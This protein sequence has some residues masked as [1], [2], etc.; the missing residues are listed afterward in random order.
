VPVHSDR[1]LLDAWADGDEASGRVLYKRYCDSITDFFARKAARDV[2]DLVQRTFM[3]CLEA[4]RGGTAVEQPRAF[5]YRIARN[6]LFDRLVREAA[7]AFDPAVTSLHD[8][9]TGPASRIDR[10]QKLQ[11]LLEALRRIPLD[12]QIAIE[13]YY[14]E[15]L[16]MSEVAEVLGVTK[17]AALNRVHRAR[18]LLREQIAALGVPDADAERTLTSFESWAR[19]LREAR[20]R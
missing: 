20:E 12:H 6:E 7:R 16:P 18:A 3:K 8:L 15:G 9:A 13:L 11:R 14:W 10:R 19:D 17:S 1:E 2:A 4:R 5:L